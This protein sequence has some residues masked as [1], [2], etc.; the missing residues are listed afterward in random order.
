[1]EG[2]PWWSNGYESARQCREHGFDRWSRKIPHAVGRRSLWT[3][4]AAA[5]PSAALLPERSR[6]SARLQAAASEQLRL[7]QLEKARG[8]QGRRSTVK[9]K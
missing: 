6:C 5:R 7:L 8:Q 9:N 2:R 3:V 1:M 4:T